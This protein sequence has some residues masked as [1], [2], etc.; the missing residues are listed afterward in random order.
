MAASTH[1]PK[2]ALMA[3]L[4]VTQSPS[5]T[6]EERRQALSVLTGFETSPNALETS[7][8]L[9]VEDLRIEGS[10]TSDFFRFYCL[11]VVLKVV[12]QWDVLPPVRREQTKTQLLN[13]IVRN[14]V[15][16]DPKYILQ[17]EAQLLAAVAVREFPEQ[18]PGLLEE[19]SR[20]SDASARLHFVLLIG[21]LVEV[22][23]CW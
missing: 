20:A 17:K 3:A 9:Y 8:S 5:A 7:L 10:R 13:I 6:S 19:L 18:W 11:K 14:R 12:E 15:R 16:P 23:E 4:G 21:N 1:G 2:A 22:G